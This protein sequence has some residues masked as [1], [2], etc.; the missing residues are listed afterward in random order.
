M[1]VCK[2]MCI[3]MSVLVYVKSIEILNICMCAYECAYATARN[4][5]TCLGRVHQFPKAINHCHQFVVM[6]ANGIIKTTGISNNN[7]TL[8]NEVNYSSKWTC[9]NRNIT[10]SVG[11]HTTPML[12]G[13]R[14]A[15]RYSR[16]AIMIR[17][18][19]ALAWLKVL[20]VVLVCRLVSW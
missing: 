20:V 17:K 3:C 7:A 2:N 11:H 1:H 8:L 13:F 4:S 18:L 12:K 5:S 14:R 19:L 9:H 6:P 10:L 15:R 16:N